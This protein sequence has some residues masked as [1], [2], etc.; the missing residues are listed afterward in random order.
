M[1][2]RTITDDWLP[3]LSIRPSAV[4]TRSTLIIS[5]AIQQ[6]R[7][8]VDPD[9][10]MNL[11]SAKYCNQLLAGQTAQLAHRFHD[12]GWQPSVELSEQ[13]LDGITEWWSR[14]WHPS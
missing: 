13:M 1:T 8:N 11:L 4:G 10:L 6:R 3:L 7:A 12:L 2:H 5:D 9:A 14:G